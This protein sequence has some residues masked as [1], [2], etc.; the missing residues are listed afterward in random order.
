[1]LVKRSGVLD[2]FWGRFWDRLVTD[3]VVALVGAFVLQGVWFALGAAI[4]DY[5]PELE[6]AMATTSTRLGG[7]WFLGL[8]VALGWGVV[9]ALRE[10]RR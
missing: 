6:D 7:P 10:A 3:W 1:M 9:R 5:R 8:V 2:D 4:V